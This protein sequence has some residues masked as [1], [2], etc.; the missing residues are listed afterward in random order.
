ML[1]LLPIV[2]A[3]A[4]F[5]HFQKSIIN[6]MAD[7]A[8]DWLQDK[9]LGWMPAPAINKIDTHHHYVPLFYSKGM[10]L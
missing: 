5:W 6:D 9:V 4:K 10:S 1:A 3:L 2:L 7:E 8:A